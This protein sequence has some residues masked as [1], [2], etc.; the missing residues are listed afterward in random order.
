MKGKDDTIL[1]KAIPYALVYI[2]IGGPLVW[3]SDDWLFENLAPQFR[4]IFSG[5]TQI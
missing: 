3:L 5:D 2:L 1:R 4:K